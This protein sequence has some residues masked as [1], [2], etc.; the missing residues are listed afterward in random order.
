[1]TT[2]VQIC[3][4]MAAEDGVVPFVDNDSAEF[5]AIYIGEPGAFE[6]QADFKHY[7]DALTYAMAVIKTKNIPLQDLTYSDR[8]IDGTHH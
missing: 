4:C 6:W 5:Y 8:N 1:M 2:I 7:D 3:G